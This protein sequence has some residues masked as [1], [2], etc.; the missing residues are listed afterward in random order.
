LTLQEAQGSTNFVVMQPAWLPPDCVLGPT[1]LRD[2]QPPGRPEGSDRAAMAQTP[3]SSGNPCSIRTLVRGAGRALR[4][5]QF[6]YDWAPPAASVAPLWDSPEL[7]PFACGGAVGWDGTD[8]RAA[9]GACIERERTQIEVSCLEGE[10]GRDEL[11][12]LLCSL[13]VAAPE[14]AAVVQRTPFHRLNY[15]V[16]YRLA[17]VRVPYGLFRYPHP[18]H[19][20]Y[21]RELR[22]PELASLA[23]AGAF[24]LPGDERL[25]LDSAVAIEH[26]A[27]A[28]HEAEAI[29]RS[30]DATGL[31]FWMT[32]VN[33]ESEWTLDLPPPDEP[34]ARALRTTYS[35]RGTTV[36]VA[37]LT[38][39]YGAWEA[40]WEE[41]RYR[42]AI[43]S[44]A[45]ED[46]GER[47]FMSFI[48]GL[49]PRP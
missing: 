5:K 31:R 10:F 32:A 39:N 46:F 35:L 8:Y 23:D 47:R 22:A 24:L 14:R 38:S 4:I 18:R 9:H 26:S 21:A 13:Q 43:W 27:A 1:S 49:R 42:Y 48:S 29:F 19:Y 28:H 45:S 40:M 17:P 6:L 36:W 44:N 33:R 7:H 16:R 11:S 12:R 41:G 34:R 25:A 30:R 15:W 20:E 37:A 3:W 2:E